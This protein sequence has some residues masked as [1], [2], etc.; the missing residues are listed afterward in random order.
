M[1]ITQTY[2]IGLNTGW[3]EWNGVSRDTQ[4]FKLDDVKI[5]P[6]IKGYKFVCIFLICC[7]SFTSHMPFLCYGEIC[8][9]HLLHE[10]YSFDLIFI[11]TEQ[12]MLKLYLTIPVATA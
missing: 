4:V 7:F 6:D 3:K 11:E 2:V 10:M 8:L 9:W 5:P 1:G 12:N